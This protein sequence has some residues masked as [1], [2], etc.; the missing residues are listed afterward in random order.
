MATEIYKTIN[1]LNPKF[2]KDIFK[3]TDTQYYLRNE[4]FDRKKPNTVL[5]GK[6]TITYRCSQ[7]WNELPSEIK[8]ASSS[9]NFKTKIKLHKSFACSCKLCLPYIH[10]VGYI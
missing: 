3:L 2:M 6:D 10:N 4:T 8:M 1:D 7:L 9:E 5:Y